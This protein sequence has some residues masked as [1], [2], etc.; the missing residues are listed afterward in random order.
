M[1]QVIRAQELEKELA[2]SKAALAAVASSGAAA[3]DLQDISTLRAQAY[4]FLP[5]LACHTFSFCHQHS[6][7]FLANFLPHQLQSANEER[8]ETQA[9]IRA[10]EK[11]LQAAYVTRTADVKLLK[12]YEDQREAA[13]AL[14]AAAD[15]EA[16]KQREAAAAAAAEVARLTSSASA[17][18]SRAEAA[19]A[20]AAAADQ[21]AVEAQRAAAEAKSNTLSA[22]AVAADVGA[23]KT[24]AEA[25]AAAQAR[26]EAQLVQ[27]LRDKQAIETTAA[28]LQTKVKEL[29]AAVAASDAQLQASLARAAADAAA[30]AREK[31]E[32]DSLQQQ[33]TE[34]RD[35][36]IATQSQ[37]SQALAAA[38]DEISQQ[39]SLAAAAS[40]ARTQAEADAM[41][42]QPLEQKLADAEAQA[43]SF[44]KEVSR[45]QEESS[46]ALAESAKLQ[47]NQQAV[48]LQLQ[49]I[50]LRF[51]SFLLSRLTLAP[52]QTQK[53]AS[54][55][56][57]AVARAEQQAS[58]HM[59]LL[60]EVRARCSSLEVENATLRAITQD[61]HSEGAESAGRFDDAGFHF[62]HAHDI[63]Y[64]RICRLAEAQSKAIQLEE[65]LRYTIWHIFA[66]YVVRPVDFDVH[67]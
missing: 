59:R 39:K 62:S 6:C 23:A 37:L 67:F 50:R 30:C 60:D 8:I 32:K 29:E 51:L 14:Q 16:S 26:A 43:R 13:L 40:N 65:A 12:T 42:L 53:K 18:Q 54:D 10:L 24:A 48:A 15:A 35:R 33:L 4:F 11:E 21:V 1:G 5:C 28:A 52:Q 2:N 64:D 3:A 27:V 22:D 9:N 31:S 20:R 57:A 7:I 49:V 41:S 38:E 56:A 44:Q 17:A 61:V 46:K 25:S 58:D 66:A 47:A 34:Y 55:S 36:A 63:Q 45:L 19:E